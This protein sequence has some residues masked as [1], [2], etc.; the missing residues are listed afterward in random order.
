MDAKLYNVTE[1]NDIPENDMEGVYIDRK[2]GKEK[3]FN[4]I[5]RIVGTV[6]DKDK[7]KHTISLLTPNSGVV[8]VKM[9]TDDYVKYGVDK[10]TGENVK[11][12]GWFNRGDLLML[13]GVK[14]EGTNYFKLHN[15]SKSCFSV[16]LAK[17]VEVEY[18]TEAGKGKIK[19][20]A[21]KEKI[22]NGKGY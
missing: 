3:P 13:T 10:V 4:K 9:S 17:I 16:K 21:S 22:G 8:T 15:R 6:L 2:T 19:Y 18:N 7:Y 1:Y 14:R 5:R 12:S 20:D 11:I